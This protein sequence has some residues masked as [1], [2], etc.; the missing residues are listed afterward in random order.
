MAKKKHILGI[1][2]PKDYPEDQQ[3]LVAEFN[4]KLLALS[5]E[6][7]RLT[8]T[9][10]K[11]DQEKQNQIVGTVRLYNINITK[12]LIEDEIYDYS[13]GDGIPIF[14]TLNLP[15][16]CPLPDF[17]EKTSALILKGSNQEKFREHFNRDRLLKAFEEG[18]YHH[19][20][21][22]EMLLKPREAPHTLHHAILLTT[23]K[24]SGDVIAMCSARDITSLIQS[25]RQL[26]AARESINEGLLVMEALLRDY[27]SIWIVNS[28]T[29]FL[30]LFRFNE[31]IV[32]GSALNQATDI[33]NYEEVL[34]SFIDKYVVE[35]ERE[36]LY[37]EIS[38]DNI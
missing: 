13:M 23:E 34:N 6:N 11:K 28:K 27:S 18:K 19:D 17:I 14:K 38:L 1:L 26:Y 7:A 37:K 32:T 36:K 10:S 21:E 16:P 8:M 33:S 30:R 24:D 29:A 25:Q 35:K 22:Y 4:Q 9:V 2:N 5:E 20:L 3:K 15:N 31:E 12:D